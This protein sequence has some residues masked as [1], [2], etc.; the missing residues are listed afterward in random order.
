MSPTSTFLQ[1]MHKLTKHIQCTDDCKLLQYALAGLQS[2]TQKWLLSLN[3]KKSCIVSYGRSV[4]KTNFNQSLLL[5][6]T[7]VIRKPS[8][9][10]MIKLSSREH[11]Q[12][13]ESG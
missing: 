3:I 10:N 4:D 7:I 13:Q 12:N 5:L 8:S 6:L 9:K 1:T 2:W 11:I